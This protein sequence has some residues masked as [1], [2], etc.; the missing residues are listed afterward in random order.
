M[1]IIKRTTKRRL[2]KR[3]QVGKLQLTCGRAAWRGTARGAR[4][5]PHGY[6]GRAGEVH[7]L[8]GRNRATGVRGVACTIRRVVH[9][10]PT[11]NHQWWSGRRRPSRISRARAPARHGNGDATRSKLGNREPTAEHTAS[12]PKQFRNVKNWLRSYGNHIAEPTY[13]TQ[14]CAARLGREA[15]EVSRVSPR[16]RTTKT[17]ARQRRMEWRS[18]PRVPLN[19]RRRL[20]GA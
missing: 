6:R 3:K 18:A 17:R 15:E 10:P 19:T 5:G 13:R 9:R 1:N 12:R 7:E 20:T 14:E 2:G 4:S 11:N 8:G 16:G